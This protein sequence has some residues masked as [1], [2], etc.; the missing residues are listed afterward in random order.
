MG[1]C[2]I[3]IRCTLFIDKCRN[4][5]PIMQIRVDMQYIKVVI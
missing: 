3:I 5:V 2:R 1:V 4:S